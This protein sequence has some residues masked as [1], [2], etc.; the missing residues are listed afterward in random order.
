MFTLAPQTGSETQHKG[1]IIAQSVEERDV[2][3][4]AA[5]VTNNSQLM[6]VQ[7][8]VQVCGK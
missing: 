5:F 7:E 4:A 8:Y 3:L 2:E 6:Q 1:E